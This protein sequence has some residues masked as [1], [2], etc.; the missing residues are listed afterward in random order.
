MRISLAL[1]AVL[2]TQTIWSGTAKAQQPLAAI[3]WLNTPITTTVLPETILLEPPVTGSALRPEIIVT[4]LRRLPQPAG[5]VSA[6]STGLPIDLWRSS[7][8]AELARL[9]ASVRVNDTPAMQALL[10]TLLLSETRPPEEDQDQLLLARLDRLMDLG[11]TDPAQALA[12]QADPTKSSARFQRWFDASLLTGDEDRACAAL[13]SAAHLAPSY[14]ERIFC[15]ARRGDWATAALLLETAHTLEILPKQ[16]LSLLDRFLNPD[17]FEFAPPPKS[18]SK[19][20]PLTFRLFESIGEPLPTSNLPRAYASADLR[21]VSGWKAQLEAA[22]R[23]AHIGALPPNRLLGLFSERKPAASGGIW[24][25]VSALQ[26]FETAIKTGSAD[27]IS[28]TLVPAWNAVQS[29]GIE[30]GFAELFA[31]EL[32]R[33]DL[34]G[35]AAEL[36]WRIRLLAPEYELAA[37][38]PPSESDANLLLA[39]VAMGKART[40]ADLSTKEFAISRAFSQD[41]KKELVP[42]NLRHKVENGRLGEAILD[43]MVLFA[44][45]S[46]GNWAALTNALA[47]FRLVGLEE[48]ARRAALQLLILDR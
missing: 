19:V 12:Q 40:D 35:S 31:E 7:D 32:A 29:S 24:D 45:G 38:L 16:D 37:M 3:D 23:L 30:T 44:Q 5:L 47:T 10:F 4:P 26:R 41:A 13:H 15:D 22:E 21:D 33:F 17:V 11:A 20:T 28:K 39:A 6:A 9:I 34:E 48:T 43:A 1:A 46:D 42:D 25:R 2:V 18:P 14:A 27:A 8:A 36:A